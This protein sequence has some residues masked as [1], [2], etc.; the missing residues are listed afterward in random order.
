PVAAAYGNSLNN[1]FHFDDAHVLVDNAWVHSLRFVPAYFTN[2]EAYNPL[3]E[4]RNYRPVALIGF[5]LSH[6]LGLGEPWGY[7]VI[8]LLLHV[9]AAALVG[10]IAGGL[11]RQGGASAAAARACALAA[12]A[13][14]WAGS[15]RPSS[16][17]SASR[18]STR[19]WS[20]PRCAP[21]AAASGPGA[22]S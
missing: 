6:A 3:L 8:T 12:R 5:A 9:A 1:P 14:G 15:A 11:L 21:R 17:P 20:V 18:C 13:P 22:T 19:S 7:H 16:L 10:L 2:V 4:N